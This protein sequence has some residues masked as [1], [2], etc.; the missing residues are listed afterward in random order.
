M[1]KASHFTDNGKRGT[2]FDDYK[3][4]ESITHHVGAGTPIIMDYRI[5]H[6]GGANTSEKLRPLLYFKFI[7]KTADPTIQPPSNKKRKRI[8]PIQLA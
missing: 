7:R 4:L 2:C 6:R 1:K 8:T 3:H 5:W